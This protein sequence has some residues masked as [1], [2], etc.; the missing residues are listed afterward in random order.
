MDIAALGIN[1]SIVKKRTFLDR[2]NQQP[3]K[4]NSN[5]YIEEGMGKVCA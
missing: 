5:H 4:A 2:E 1:T 3:D